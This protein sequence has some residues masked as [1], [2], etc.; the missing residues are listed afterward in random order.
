VRESPVFFCQIFDK[1]N[2][3]NLANWIDFEDFVSPAADPNRGTVS[4]RQGD[5]LKSLS[6]NDLRVPFTCQS[7]TDHL[8]QGC[9]VWTMGCS[10]NRSVPHRTIAE[11]DFFSYC[12]LSPVPS[13]PCSG[14]S[15][16]H[17]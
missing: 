15:L 4:G 3:E 13:T 14:N 7:G 6:N 12:F 2:R 9:C 5:L 16:S 8:P 10:I 17:A 1:G 11:P